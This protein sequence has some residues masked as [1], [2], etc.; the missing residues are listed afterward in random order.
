MIL[1][2]FVWP[3]VRSTSIASW[4]AIPDV[5]AMRLLKMRDARSVTIR[6]KLKFDRGGKNGCT[7]DRPCTHDRSASIQSTFD[8]IFP[9][10]SCF[11]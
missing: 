11:Y 1:F 10:F 4:V 6:V 8:G 3:A 9:K 2:P 5:P 7:R